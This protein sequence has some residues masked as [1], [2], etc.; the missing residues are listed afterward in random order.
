MATLK[1]FNEFINEGKV[2]PGPG[3]Q[4]SV[5][6]EIDSDILK[7]IKDKKFQGPLPKEYTI[8]DDKIYIWDNNDD[9]DFISELF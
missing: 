2:L 5:G 1:K 8:I 4:G 6:F 7:E 9:Y 3:V